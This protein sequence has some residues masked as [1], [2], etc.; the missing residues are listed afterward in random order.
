MISGRGLGI[1]GGTLDKLES[2]PGYRTDLPAGEFL[3]IVR[4][5]GCSIIGQTAELAPADRKLYALRDVTGTVPSIPLITASI[6]SKKFA[7]GAQALVF[8]VKCGSGAFMKTRR[9][10]RALADSLVRTGQGLGRKV[11]A[12][13]SD[14]DQPLGRK[15]GNFLEVEEII[16]C[17]RGR[18]PADVVDLTMRLVAW[19]LVAGGICPTTAGGETLARARLADGSAW[20]LFQKSVEFQGGDVRCI[21]EPARGPRAPVVRELASPCDG[22]VRRIDAWKVGVASVVVGAGRSRKEDPVYPGV[23]VTLLK[24]Q[25]DPVRRGEPLALVH[26]QDERTVTEALALC[27]QAFDIGPTAAAPRPRVIE[28]LGGGA[29]PEESAGT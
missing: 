6:M 25:P 22:V 21:L 14:M 12:V 5:C 19:M 13:L 17:L 10:A 2:I 26:G 18:G 16:D 1:T 15:I 29:L 23:G 11:V 28:E 24:V 9:D 8:D 7:E 3:D 20:K 27:G 4:T